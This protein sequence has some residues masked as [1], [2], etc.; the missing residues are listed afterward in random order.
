MVFN[1]QGQGNG[2][3]YDAPREMQDLPAG[4]AYHFRESDDATTAR[5]SPVS[6]P[7]EPDY[8]QLSPPPPLGAQ[9]PVPEQNESSRDL[10]H[11]SY[12]GSHNSFDGHSYGQN[13]YGHNSYG[14]GAF[15]HYPADQHGRMPGSPGY[16]YPEPEYD[17]EASRLAESRLSVMHRTPTM[18]EWGQNGETLSV[19]ADFV[20]GRPDST[21]QEFDVDESW[22]M[23]Q[24]Q[25]Q[26]AGGLGRS[27]TR[28]V[29]LVQ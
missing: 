19:P 15:G 29:K 16:E 4:Q 23:R 18:Q 14:P 17:V 25:Y 1:P 21:Y 9:R 5:V 2:P 3:N 22:M 7:Y 8:E 28:K 12:Q 6:S 26:L 11:S 20:H 27:K 24:Q 10:L 13:S